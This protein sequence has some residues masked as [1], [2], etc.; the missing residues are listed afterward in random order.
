MVY[1]VAAA[2]AVLAV[3]LG[4]RLL[5]IKKEVR[6]AAEELR[7]ISRNLEENRVLKL[8]T[9]DRDLE[10]FFAGINQTLREIRRER[11]MFDRREQEF[12]KQIENISHDLRTPLTSILGYLRIM[13]IQGLSG[14]DRAGLETVRRKAEALSR[15][16]EQFYEYSR[17]TAEE[18]EPEMK[19]LDLG[20]LLRETLADS[21]REI[22]ESGLELSAEIPEMPVLAQGD[23]NASERILRNLIQ[24]GCRYASGV[25]KVRL[26]VEEKAIVLVFENDVKEFTEEDAERIFHRFY[27]KDT[28]RNMQGTGLGLSIART[29]A[30]KMGGS[31]KAELSE[32]EKLRFIFCFRRLEH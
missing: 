29:L 22:E 23:T 7:E 31:M 3:C 1:I 27:V 25:L 9:G 8:H 19:A 2:A 14:E 18:Y 10:L 21:W 20:R 26:T 4:I 17:I 30:E 15:L 12:K 32:R 11:N 13:D 28:S 24:N 16:V 5:L 6:D